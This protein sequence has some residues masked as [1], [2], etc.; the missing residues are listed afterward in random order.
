MFKLM[1]YRFRKTVFRQKS[2]I[3]VAYWSDYIECHCSVF[4][5]GKA[6]CESEDSME[7]S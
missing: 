5:G 2:Q 3:P 7:G 1:F 4:D 6:I